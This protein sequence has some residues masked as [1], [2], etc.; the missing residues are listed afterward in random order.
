MPN[1]CEGILKIRGNHENV[2]N[3]L[4][5]NLQVW[6]TIFPRELHLDVYDELDTEAIKIDAEY[7]EI[8]LKKEAHIKGT[9]RNFATSDYIN[10][11]KRKDG[12]SC[13][14]VEFKAAWDVEPEP[15]IELSKNYNVD[16]K[17]E[18]FERG[19]EFSRY[20]LIKDGRLEE[21]KKIEYEDY[22]WDCVM[23]LLGG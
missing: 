19:L 22:I 20:I 2:F 1:W 11:C 21:N 18:A 9:Y 16:I 6:T 13:V 5:E 17:V 10:V 3:L 4:V 15:Y 23:P 7:N 8:I 12:S 14:A